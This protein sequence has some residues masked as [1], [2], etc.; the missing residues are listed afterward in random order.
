MGKYQCW[1]T[2]KFHLGSLLFLN[3]INNLTE[4]LTTNAQLIA[5]DTSLFSV[6]YD[7]QTSANDLNKRHWRCSGVFIVNFE[8]ISH[9]ALV[10][11]F[12]TLSR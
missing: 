12:L 2:S 9:L 7:T 3:Y 6:V 8:H 10:F 5:D 11:L 4:G 1:S